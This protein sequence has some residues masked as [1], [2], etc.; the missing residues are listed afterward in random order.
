MILTPLKNYF[1]TE[2]DK[3]QWMKVQRKKLLNF[4]RPPSI[5]QALKGALSQYEYSTLSREQYKGKCIA[6][7]HINNGTNKVIFCIQIVLTVVL[8]YGS[9][10]LQESE[11]SLGELAP[12]WLPDSCVSMCMTCTMRFTVTRRRHHCRGCGKVSPR[13]TRPSCVFTRV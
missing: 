5:L 6:N 13:Y 11:G 8:T 3:I 4:M 1:S 2:E 12:A 10:H 7:A 9:I